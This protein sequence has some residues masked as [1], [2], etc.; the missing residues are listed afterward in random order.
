MK[1][2]EACRHCGSTEFG[3]QSEETEEALEF[4]IYCKNCLKVDYSWSFP[5]PKSFGLED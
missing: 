2:A 1:H 3:I 4:E 5:K